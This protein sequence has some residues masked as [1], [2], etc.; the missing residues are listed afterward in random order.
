MTSEMPAAEK[1][2]PDPSGERQTA[3]GTGIRI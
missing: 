2:L 3:S 1:A